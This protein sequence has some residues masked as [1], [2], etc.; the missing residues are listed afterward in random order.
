[1][2]RSSAF[3]SRSHR[4]AD[5]NFRCRVTAHGHAE[6]PAL[7][8]KPYQPASRCA[9]TPLTTQLNAARSR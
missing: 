8:G 5:E 7:A 2:R 9:L 4:A 6:L 1:M 3:P